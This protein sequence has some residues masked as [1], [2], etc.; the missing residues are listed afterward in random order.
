M[1]SKLSQK[2]NTGVMV[3]LIIAFFMPPLALAGAPGGQTAWEEVRQG[4]QR[5]VESESLTS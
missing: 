3:L 4:D 1:K 5:P 2:S